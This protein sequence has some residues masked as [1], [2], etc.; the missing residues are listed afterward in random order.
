MIISILVAPGTQYASA[1]DYEAQINRLNQASEDNREARSGLQTQAT[2]LQDQI[3]QLDA[4]IGG[5]E[6]QIIA[7]Q[8]E[9][10]E[11]KVKIAKT[12]EEIAQQ[13][14]VLQQNVRAI[15]IEGNIS[16]ME[17][18]VASDTIGDYLDK[19]QYREVIQE[20][21]NDMIDQ[22][23]ALQAKLEQQKVR[24]EKLISDQQTMQARLT[25]QKAEQARLLT[26]NKSQQQ[27]HNKQIKSN[28]AKVAEL[29]RQ[30]AAENARLAAS[31]A[32]GGYT[33]G[34]GVNCGG[35]YPGDT[36]GPWG[37]WG[38]NYPID[39]AV[40][41]WGMYNRQ[42][43]SYTA[44]RVANSGRHMP[45]WGGYGNAKNWDDNARAAG[46]P[47]DYSPRAGDVAVS[48]AGYYGHVM[49]VEQVSNGSILVSDYNQQWDGRYRQY[50]ID[51][52]T[53]SARGL[54]FIHF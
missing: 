26:L 25:N 1:V 28:N 32:G 47:V 2:S 29:R 53:V 23:N 3:A 16:T 30:Q 8:T 52:G 46:I 9:R 22:I 17:M 54:V 21:I 35:G 6:R 50:W 10:A 33:A 39:N 24:V 44:F 48:N 4:E 42:C 51:S 15:Y 43:V 49:Y 36:P 18:L 5:L 40:D 20:K 14:I 11:L 38:C 13:K 45:Y 37:R 27:E 7:N 19:E 31:S 41:T 12:K 34:S